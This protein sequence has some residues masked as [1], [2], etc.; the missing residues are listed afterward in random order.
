MAPYRPADR[1]AG[2]RGAG[3]ARHAGNRRPQRVSP[4]RFPFLRHFPLRKHALSPGWAWK[5]PC[6][7]KGS[8]ICVAGAVPEYCAK[9]HSPGPFLSKAGDLSDFP[10][11]RKS[12]KK[13]DKFSRTASEVGDFYGGR[14]VTGSGKS[15]PPPITSSLNSRH[16]RAIIRRGFARPLPR[17]VT[18]PKGTHGIGGR[19]QRSPFSPEA[20]W[21]QCWQWAAA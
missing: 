16:V 12:L 15:L 21:R 4:F 1:Q 18:Q 19:L 3:A 13:L 9:M 6:Y 10:A 5:I 17:G 2:A 20:A 7:R 8:Q 11:R 14:R